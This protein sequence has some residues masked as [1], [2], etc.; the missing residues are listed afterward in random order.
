MEEIQ[1]NHDCILF[2]IIIYLK[3]YPKHN[4]EVLLITIVLK[5]IMNIQF[6]LWFIILQKF[7]SY[8]IGVSF[9]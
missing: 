6:N 5:C 4:M 7:F 3:L 1:Q 9:I 8:I 2:N